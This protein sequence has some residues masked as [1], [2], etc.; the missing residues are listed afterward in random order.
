MSLNKDY[1]TW[2]QKDVLDHAVENDR[3]LLE[4]YD[5]AMKVAEYV[6][7]YRD[8]IHRFAEDYIGVVLKPFQKFLMYMLHHHDFSLFVMTRGIG[9]SWLIAVYACCL[10][11]LYPNSEIIIVSRTMK[12]SKSIVELKILGDLFKKSPRLSKEMARLDRFGG[13]TII[14]FKN[15]SSITPAVAGE[16]S[17]G[18]RSTCIIIDESR[19]VDS[20]IVQS[21]LQPTSHPRQ[22][23]YMDFPEFGAKYYPNDESKD[24]Y[25]TSAW[26]KAHPLYQQFI[27]FNKGMIEGRPV[28]TCALSVETAL[29]NG[30][31]S[32]T[33]L[34]QVKNQPDMSHIRYSM[35][36]ETL[37][38]GE[39]EDAFF[40][41]EEIQGC[42]TLDRPFYCPTLIDYKK[43]INFPTN[44]KKEKDEIRIISADIALAVGQDNDA[45]AFTLV[46]LIPNEHGRYERYIVNIETF[47]G[48]NS[49]DQAVRLKQLF[50][51]FEADYIVLDAITIGISVY[52][53]LC[54]VS[55]DTDRGKTYKAMSAF[56]DEDLA[57]K[58]QEINAIPCI[59][60]IK[61]TQQ[62]NHECH[63]IVQDMIQRNM[64]H[65]LTD[66]QFAKEEFLYNEYAISEKHAE[67]QSFFI[68]PYLQTESLINEMI[69]LTTE[70]RG[71][72]VRLS[73]SSQKRRKDRYMS[74]AYANYFAN[75]LEQ[76]IGQ[77]DDE[78]LWGN[79]WN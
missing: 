20:M 78:E 67:K 24:I 72:Y 9:K 8:N 25:L 48:A 34:E 11:V 64:I 63:V 30:L 69:N 36:Y 70:I 13:N 45:S 10:A 52:D 31:L 1:T 62:V 65:F 27:A 73:E 51:D 35:E 17:R 21:I 40:N 28:F 50:Y 39:S 57:K 7:F 55:E 53:N 18:L 54:R 19:L 60:A 56:N 33:R 32:K 47:E 2:T 15:G 61:G 16:A 23:R 58:C 68:A 43:R 41:L 38:Y 22:T 5:F 4:D 77:N 59:F 49:Y 14:H 76:D 75:I 37:F 42:Q 79:F 44:Q 29:N 12:Q 46:R 66:T 3:L 6:S 74:L 71:G 26:F